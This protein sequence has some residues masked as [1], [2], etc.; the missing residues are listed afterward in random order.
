MVSY[1]LAQLTDLSPQQLLGWEQL[2]CADAIFASPYF[3]PDFMR[4]MSRI[5]HR[6]EV[7][8][9]EEQNQLVGLL[10]FERTRWNVGR[11]VGALCRTFMAC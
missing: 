4:A 2:L 7:L 8:L 3:R 5:G 6:V 9:L 10:P 1:S 11:P